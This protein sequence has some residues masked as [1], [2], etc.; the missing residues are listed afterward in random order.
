MLLETPKEDTPLTRKTSDVDPL[1]R[2]NLDVLRRL[3]QSPSPKTS[4]AKR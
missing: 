2:M 3:L 4:A 1:D